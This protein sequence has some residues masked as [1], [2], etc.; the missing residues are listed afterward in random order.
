MN[1]KA[2]IPLAA[3]LGIGG[4]ALWMGFSTLKSARGSQKPAEDVQVWSAQADIP[5]GTEITAE[6]IAAVPFP[7]KLVPEGAITDQEQLLGRV[8]RLDAPAGLPILEK[9]LLAPGARAG[10]H[11]KP[12]FRAVAVKIDAGSGVDFHLEPGCFVDVVGSFT[13]RR[14]NRQET[15]ARIIVENV[16]VAAVGPRVSPVRSGDL[17]EKTTKRTVRA[18]TL[19]VHPDDVPKLLLAEQ[20]GKIKLSMRNDEDGGKVASRRAIS[21]RELTGEVPEKETKEGES[22]DAKAAGSFLGRLRGMFTQPEVKP[23]PTPL[24]LAAGPPVLAS[25]PWEIAIYR[26]QEREIVRFKDRDSR[27]LVDDDAENPAQSGK[28]GPAAQ[29]EL[30]PPST[31]AA[32][33]AASDEDKQD[34]EPEPMEEPQE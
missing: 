30:R 32:A 8:P 10:I 11:V 22:E 13:V 27:E 31:T 9:M 12:G 34:A 1:G 4:F 23:A 7:T 16:E 14:D 24:Q 19:F 3:G 17:E 26:G 18:V 21:D 5:R 20:K 28:V 6:M 33:L 29:Q 15:L 25:P 2:L